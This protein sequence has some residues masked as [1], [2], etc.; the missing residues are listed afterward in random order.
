M[1]KVYMWWL[2][3]TCVRVAYLGRGVEGYQGSTCVPGKYLKHAAEYMGSTCGEWEVP[4]GV[5]VRSGEYL[6]EYL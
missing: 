1:Y 4:G 5:P 6:G 3:S 2:G